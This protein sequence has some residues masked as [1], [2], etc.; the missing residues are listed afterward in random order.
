MIVRDYKCV[1][2]D[3]LKDCGVSCLLT[4]I[5]YYNGDMSKEELIYLTNTTKSGVDLFSLAMAARKI[6][7]DASGVKGNVK[8]L[9][10]NNLPCIAHVVMNKSYKHF[11]VIFHINIKN[12]YMIIGDPARGVKKISIKYFNSISTGYYLLL[13]PIGKIPKLND[14]KKITNYIFSSVGKYRKMFLNLFI[15]S[16]FIII[17]N[18]VSAYDFKI[19]LDKALNYGSYHNAYSIAVCLVAIIFL[20][21]I[22]LYLKNLLIGYLDMVLSYRLITSIYEHLILLPYLYC[23]NH[24]TGEIITR[25]NDVVM[26]KDLISKYV[27]ELIVNILLSLVTFIIIFNI[28]K[29]LSFILLLSILIYILISVFYDFI[30]DKYIYNTEVFNNKINTHII[31]TFEG[32]D[33]IKNLNLE[34]KFRFNMGLKYKEFLNNNYTLIKIY[35]RENTIRNIINDTLNV[36]ILLFGIIFVIDKKMTVSSLIVFISLKNYFIDPIK[37]SMDFKTNFIK[38]KYSFERIKDL[39][40]IKK[41]DQIIKND[42]GCIE[43]IIIKN[44]E[45]SY[46]YKNRILKGINLDIERCDRILIKGSSGNGKSTLVKI[47]LK[48]LDID[49][50]KVFINNNDI[51]DFSVSSIRNR[52]C[53]ISQN[54][55]IFSDTVINN[56]MMNRNISYDDFLNMCKACFVDEIVKRNDLGYNLLLEEN[57]FNLSG[58]E[59]QRIILARS[60]LKKADI[61][62]LDESL[63]EVDSY[64]ERMILKNI[65]KMYSDKIFIIITHRETNFD[66]FNKI[67]T[68]KNGRLYYE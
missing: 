27:I 53:L 19:L 50:G 23:K 48:Y 52:I 24:R 9:S 20:K 44:L 11:I 66:L 2:Q 32:I 17:F 15:V 46:Y 60:L 12:N 25:I 45:Y 10:K 39:Y 54:E 67:V 33:T 36:I 56:V 1:K 58:G 35:N 40:K 43:S 16:I 14:S 13:T 31:E 57:G 41:E 34:N 38:G 29:T 61:Y 3:N 37:T 64:K 26:L 42:C 51:V 4:I 55:F 28:N 22:S 5:N 65:F 59:K 49:R 30:L 8:G 18:I 21:N 62:I 68:L 47:I 63:G 7:F 6:G